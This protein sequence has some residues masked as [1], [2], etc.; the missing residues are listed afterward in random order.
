MLEKLS[1]HV[2]LKQ[3]C[4]WK[5]V[6]AK[7]SYKQTEEIIRFRSHGKLL[8]RYLRRRRQQPGLNRVQ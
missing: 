4:Y 3:T 8:M 2:R 7:R 1:T 6:Q 5:K